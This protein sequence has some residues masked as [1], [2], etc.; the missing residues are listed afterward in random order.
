MDTETEEDININ[1]TGASSSQFQ[2]P[3][4]GVTP[5]RRSERVRR[6]DGNVSE[7]EEP[8]QSYQEMRL[9]WS[10][11]EIKLLYEAVKAAGGVDSYEELSRLIPSKSPKEIKKYIEYVCSLELGR[12]PQINRMFQSSKSDLDEWLDIMSGLTMHDNLPLRRAFSNAINI[13][14]KFEDAS[15]PAVDENGDLPDDSPNYPAIYEWIATLILGAPEQP[16]KLRPIDAMIVLDL[17]D[18][19][20]QTATER[21][22]K[23]I[24]S[25]ELLKRKTKLLSAA[26]SKYSTGQSSQHHERLVAL[27]LASEEQCDLLEFD[28]EVNNSFVFFLLNCICF[29]LF[30]K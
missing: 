11:D 15:F 4:A 10:I 3:K 1:E 13:I 14:G 28:D 17:M 23:K 9:L 5:L 24:P 22:Q 20:Q 6:E 26:S 18:Q 7:N 12:A 25:I 16:K 2:K 29:I 19:M 27:A 8:P 30:R 21:I